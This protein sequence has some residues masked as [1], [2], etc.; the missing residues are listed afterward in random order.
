MAPSKALGSVG[1]PNAW[2]RA[3]ADGTIN[4]PTDIL[5]VAQQFG[6]NCV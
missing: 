2:N 4:I 3:P 6:Q 5:G 1:W